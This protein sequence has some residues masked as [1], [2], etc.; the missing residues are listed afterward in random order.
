MFL[1]WHR[2]GESGSSRSEVTDGELGTGIRYSST[3]HGPAA[4]VLLGSLL[5]MPVLAPNPTPT[6]T[7]SAKILA[8]GDGGREP[9]L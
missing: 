8:G 1:L 7:R 9:I 2:A 5:E 3:A 6:P 4:S